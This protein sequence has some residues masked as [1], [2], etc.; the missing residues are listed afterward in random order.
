MAL[1]KLVIQD[2][3]KVACSD[4][5]AINPNV[6]RQP[7]AYTNRKTKGVATQ[8]RFR[9]KCRLYSSFTK[10]DSSLSGEPGN[11]RL[12]PV[13]MK[14]TSSL[15]DQVSNMTKVLERLMKTIE[16]SDTQIPFLMKKLE[17]VGESSQANNDAPK[18][19][20]TSETIATTQ[21]STRLMLL[22]LR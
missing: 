3:K 7:R 13:M 2:L 5:A 8:G 9:T 18:Q 16:E 21:G 12:L 22:L 17:N 11:T 19:T 6:M 4:D 20:Q 15:E 14:N 10:E 1:R